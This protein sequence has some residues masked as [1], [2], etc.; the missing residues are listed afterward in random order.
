MITTNPHFDLCCSCEPSIISQNNPNYN[1]GAVNTCNPSKGNDVGNKLCAH[2]PTND[3]V[4]KVFQE[5][6]VGITVKVD[7]VDVYSCID[8]HPIADSNDVGP[9]NHILA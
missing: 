5:T 1:P 6:P 3:L 4:G 9:T 7:S 8:N 2:D